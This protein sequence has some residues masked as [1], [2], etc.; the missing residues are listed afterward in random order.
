MNTPELDQFKILIV[1]D[2]ETTRAVLLQALRNENFLCFEASDLDRAKVIVKKARP[3]LIILDLSFPQGDG[4]DFLKEIRA[5]DDLPIIVCTGRSDHDDKISGLEIGADDY[6]TKPFSSKELATRV[7]T[8]LRR[9]GTSPVRGKLSF[10]NIEIHLSSREVLKNGKNITLTS[11]E[12]DLLIHL[13]KH[14][15]TVFSREALLKAVW[16]QQGTRTNATVTEHIRR[17]RSKIE[18]DPDNPKYLTAVRGVG[19]RLQP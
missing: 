15:R 5:E 6:I 11:R 17:L 2:E 1:D 13:A 16:S 4:I 18:D 8:V 19:Y 10:G 14:P 7:R 3:D 9:S 12:F